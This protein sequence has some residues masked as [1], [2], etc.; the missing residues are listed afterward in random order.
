MRN[1]GHDPY[2]AAVLVR[3]FAAV[4]RLRR[5]VL[6][7]VL[8][9]AVV[10][11]AAAESRGTELSD[12][13]FAVVVL[14]FLASFALSLLA[15]ACYRP[16][17]LT[18]W[19]RARAFATPLNPDLVFRTAGFTLMGGVVIGGD[20]RHLVRHDRLWGV[21]G[22]GCAV[23]VLLLALL[24]HRAWGRYGVQLRPDG[25]LD[26]QPLGSRFVPWDAFAPELPVFAAG[27]QRL[28]IRCRRP[29]LVRRRGITPHGNTL[30]VGADPG[31]LCRVI[32]DYVAHPGHRS[33]IGT[34][35]ELRRLD[36][37][38]GS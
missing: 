7:A 27:N 26:R 28:A 15:S 35:A 16:A 13:A 24:W 19:P 25:V 8:V 12:A 2:H 30:P 31:Y 21:D 34:E 9:L 3:S 36:A 23:W 38:T 17:T 22:A 14:L 10:L 37:V 1:P 33:A 32:Q 4:A 20:V 5:L 11:A 29:D 18:V 6:P